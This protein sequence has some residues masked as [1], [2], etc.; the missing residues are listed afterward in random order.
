MIKNYFLI[1]LRNLSKNKVYSF[2]NIAGLAVGIAVAMLIGLWVWD[3]L[4]F[5]KYHKNYD[6]LTQAYISQ[7]FNKQTGSGRAVSL[8]SVMEMQTKYSADFKNTSA[9]IVEFWAFAGQW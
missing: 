5:N 2:I 3:E 8:P 4:S 1:A 6:R 7:T 9:G